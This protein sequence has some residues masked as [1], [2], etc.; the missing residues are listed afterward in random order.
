MTLRITF[1]LS[2]SVTHCVQ[3]IHYS[4]NATSRCARTNCHGQRLTRR[5]SGSGAAVPDAWTERAVGPEL[6][7]EWK[8]DATVES[9]DPTPSGSSACVLYWTLVDDGALPD[10]YLVHFV[11]LL[12][13]VD[14]AGARHARASF[15]DNA[16]ADLFVR[17]RPGFRASTQE[18]QNTA[19]TGTLLGALPEEGRRSVGGDGSTY[20]PRCLRI[21]RHQPDNSASPTR[22]IINIWGRS[23]ELQHSR[24]SYATS[25]TYFAGCRRRT[26]KSTPPKSLILSGSQSSSR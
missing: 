22:Q 14:A 18:V 3:L 7:D 1:H 23:G 10:G 5:G 2:T 25:K 17:V 19:G 24:R 21:R 8:K 13:S 20:S 15:L 12:D 26:R 6:R 16:Q 4:R 9:R 11:Q